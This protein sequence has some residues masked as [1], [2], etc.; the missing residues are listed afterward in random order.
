MR[1]QFQ[2]IL[3]PP[4]FVPLPPSDLDAATEAWIGEVEDNGGVITERQK[5]IVDN[6]ILTLKATGIW[7]I[8][9]DLWI[10]A[11]E[12]DPWQSRIGLRNH[13]ALGIIGTPVLSWRGYV[14]DGSSA[15]DSTI[16]P[17][18][19]GLQY[20]IGGASV[21][22]YIAS[23]PTTIDGGPF[24][25]NLG[26]DGPGQTFLRWDAFSVNVA[27][28]RIN[29]LTS[30]DGTVSDSG[31]QRADDFLLVVRNDPDSPN[32]RVYRNGAVIGSVDEASTGLPNQSIAFGG[33]HDS[34][35]YNPGDLKAYGIGYVG[36]WMDTT[37]AADLT[38]AVLVYLAA[39]NI[40]P[41]RNGLAQTQEPTTGSYWSH[42]GNLTIVPNAAMA[43]DGQLT[44]NQLF[45]ATSTS[46][47]EVRLGTVSWWAASGPSTYSI[48][49]KPN[50]WQWVYLRMYTTPTDVTVWFDLTAGTVETALDP[51]THSGDIEAL[52]D[53]W[54]RCSVTIFD[55][56]SAVSFCGFTI[57]DGDGAYENTADGTDGVY[58]C[59]PQ[60]NEGATALPY[61]RMP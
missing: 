46:Y 27:R 10:T 4:K 28:I 38:A 43:P 17:S 15:L 2:S 5:G 40:R 53:G 19:G 45:V 47:E 34:G 20:N 39:H 21:G 24:S 49:I 9:D 55:P 13:R 6:L 41:Y 52:L 44:A 48:Y 58:F 3:Q 37:N 60:L 57:C 25:Y 7:S 26:A 50:G 33:F 11:G 35:G 22:V 36:G 30:L 61:N 42:G 14:V 23:N 31:S 8:C 1:R 12:A 32:K 18:A 56:P 29:D 59:Y 54:F 51:L 16:V